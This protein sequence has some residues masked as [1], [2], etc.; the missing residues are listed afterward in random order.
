MQSSIQYKPKSISDTSEIN[1]WDFITGRF[2]W[3]GSRKKGQA[4]AQ[5]IAMRGQAEAEA[6]ILEANAKLVEAQ[7]KAKKES[8][9]GLGK[10]VFAIA[11]VV[12][13]VVMIR[14]M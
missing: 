3:D 5:S 9:Q 6:R 14:K 4:E 2:L 12:V 8:M 7:A 13:A 10:I 1:F 11:I